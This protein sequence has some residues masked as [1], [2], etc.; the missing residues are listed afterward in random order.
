MSKGVSERLVEYGKLSLYK[1]KAI[2]EMLDEKELNTYNFSPRINK[3]SGMLDRQKNKLSNNERTPRHILL[4]KSASGSRSGSPSRNVS[5][6]GGGSNWIGNQGSNDTSRNST[7]EVFLARVY[8]DLKLRK[9][10]EEYIKAQLNKDN[11][12]KEM[13]PRIIH[14]RLK[15]SQRDVSSS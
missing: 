3:L 9:Q 1:K 11:L 10:K 14:R 4:Q 7:N 2:K 8:E 15:E 12:R 13:N 6:I 5:S